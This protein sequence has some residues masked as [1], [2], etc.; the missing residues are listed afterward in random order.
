MLS[1]LA[2]SRT[3][4]ICAPTVDV[5]QNKY[6]ICL[7][8][9]LYK[10]RPIYGQWWPNYSKGR[11]ASISRAPENCYFP[12]TAEGTFFRTSCSI[13]CTYNIQ[14]IHIYLLEGYENVAKVQS[15][16]QQ[17]ACHE[18]QPLWRAEACIHKERHDYKQCSGLLK[19]KRA[20]CHEST[21]AQLVDREKKEKATGM[22]AQLS[23]VMRCLEIELKKK[24]L[25]HKKKSIIIKCPWWSNSIT[26]AWWPW[27]NCYIYIYIYAYIRAQMHNQKKKNTTR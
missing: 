12:R 2:F 18:K 25:R 13:R 26:A 8:R 27:P 15:P 9:S 23:T 21:L 4:Q 16:V 1:L 10:C 5:K 7:S 17:S 6:F 24:K 22:S 14:Y 3:L 20:A 19:M 11:R